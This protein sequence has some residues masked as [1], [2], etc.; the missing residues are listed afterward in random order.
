MPAL[1]RC[2][3]SAADFTDLG[4]VYEVIYCC[5]GIAAPEAQF[6]VFNSVLPPFA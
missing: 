1:Q 2:R 6:S 5:S 4:E 3:G